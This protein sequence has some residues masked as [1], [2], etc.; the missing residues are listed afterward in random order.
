M[1]AMPRAKPRAR[2]L[3]SICEDP[4]QRA[5]VAQ[6]LDRD[7]SAAAIAR[8]SK[9][10]E[11]MGDLAYGTVLRHTTTC[12]RDM[13]HPLPSKRTEALSQDVAVLVQAEVVK[14]LREGE[15]RVTVQHGLQ[16]QALIDRREER[17]KDREL[18][19][20]LARMLHAPSPPDDLVEV[21]EV[22]DVTPSY[23]ID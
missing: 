2:V 19:I 23:L 8:E 17:A 6:C 11:G 3:C 5:F 15:A 13:S 14:K 16:A 10:V 21:R 22:I 9:Y 12:P 7:M 18:A 1:S 4:E 20:T